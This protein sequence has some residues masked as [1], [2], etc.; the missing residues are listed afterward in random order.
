[1]KPNNLQRAI[2]LVRSGQLAVSTL[3]VVDHRNMMR[4]PK[5]KELLR[6]IF[7]GMSEDST[8]HLEDYYWMEGAE[9]KGHYRLPKGAKTISMTYLM[10]LHEQENF[11]A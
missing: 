10:K 3:G 9:I 6:E 7:T 11:K 1:M 5:S 8:T 4:V 2:E